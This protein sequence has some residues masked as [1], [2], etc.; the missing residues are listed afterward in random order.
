VLTTDASN[1]GAG[2]VL[3]QGPIGKDLPV[4]YASRKFNRV[5]ENYSTVERELAAIVWGI[6]HFRRYLYGR[7]FKIFS[8]HKPLTW[9]MS[10]KDPGSR[11]MGWRIQLEEYDY[12]IMHKPGAQDSN[13]D[14][15]SRIGSL[16]QGDGELGEIYPSKKLKILQ[17]N[18]DSVLGGHRGMKKTYKII[19]RYY[20]WPN[21]KTEVE[22]YVKKCAK[23]Q[24]KKALR[25]KKRAPMQIT[26]TARYPFEKC[27]LDIVGPFTETASG[28]K[29]ILPFL[30][31]L[32]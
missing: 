12:E 19:K 14:A 31:D 17:E 22:N 16:T 25:P 27:A 11:L 15:L 18:H 6:K 20:H 2:A 32:S 8:D 21:M 24:L 9:I 4:A 30:D 3:S 5:E 29:Y 26:T 1:E 23:C 10:V 13:A 28:I 7:K